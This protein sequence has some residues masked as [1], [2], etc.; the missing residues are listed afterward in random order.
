MAELDQFMLQNAATEGAMRGAEHGFRLNSAA[1]LSSTVL[2][3]IFSSLSSNKP[4]KRQELLMQ[5]EI[6]QRKRALGLPTTSEDLENL[7]N[8]DDSVPSP[9]RAIAFGAVA[10][11]MKKPL[12]SLG[13]K[14]SFGGFEHGSLGAIARIFK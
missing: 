8:K 4:Q 12:F 1:S 7:V 14:S 6:L 10:A 13:G 2:E 9:G 11:G 5:L 3:R